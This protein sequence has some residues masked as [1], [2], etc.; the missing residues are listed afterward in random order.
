MYLKMSKFGL[1]A[2][3]AHGRSNMFV[4]RKNYHLQPCQLLNYFVYLNGRLYICPILAHSLPQQGN[5]MKIS[6]LMYILWMIFN[7]LNIY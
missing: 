2:T 6:Y 4:I 7:F 1:R 3:F 5:E